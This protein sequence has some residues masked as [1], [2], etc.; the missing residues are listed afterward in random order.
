M[1]KYIKW[2]ERINKKKIITAFVNCNEQSLKKK[3]C[4]IVSNIYESVFNNKEKWDDALKYVANGFINEL[5][6]ENFLSIE[7]SVFL[8]SKI[9]NYAQDELLTGIDQL[10]IGFNKFFKEGNLEIQTNSVEAI[11]EILSGYI[12]KKISKRFR[13]FTFY[14]LQ[15]ILNCLNNND[16]NNLKRSLFSL[17]DLAQT[18]PIMLKKSF[19]D[20]YILMG[21]IIERKDLDEDSMR[22]VSYE[23]LLSI[24]EK[25]PKVISDDEERLKLLINSIFK[26][27]MEFDEEIDDDWLTPK[28]LSLSDED[29]IP[30]AKLDEALSLIDRLIISVKE[31]VALPIVS[32]IIMELLN[33]QN[34]NWKYKYI[35]YTSVGKISNYI[36]DLKTIENMVNAIL[37]DI[38]NENP[39]ILVYFVFHNL[40]IHLKTILSKVII[41]ILFLILLI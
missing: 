12:D 24:I 23:V 35:A 41:L 36:D 33:H 13:E 39:D 10:I 37:P 6:P 7:S 5:K 19:S 38:N 22:S 26:Y 3:Y 21:K 4:D 20:I 17:S 34:E 28:S 14:I 40:L 8:L 25:Y 31:K 2:I 32:N 16:F 18:Q 27:G 9:F 1:E 29:F 30:E 15:T 11:C